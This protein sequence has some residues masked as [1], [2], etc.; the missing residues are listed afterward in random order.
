MVISKAI[1]TDDFCLNVV[2]LKSIYITVYGVITSIPFSIT[3][4]TR[5]LEVIFWL[6]QRAILMVIKGRYSFDT[7]AFYCWH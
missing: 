1:A 7:H 5:F 2:E 4:T 3:W 6:E